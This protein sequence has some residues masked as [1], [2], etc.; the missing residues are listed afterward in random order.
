MVGM[1][2]GEQDKPQTHINIFQSFKGGAAVN[3]NVIADNDRISL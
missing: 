3:H 1:Y 2:M